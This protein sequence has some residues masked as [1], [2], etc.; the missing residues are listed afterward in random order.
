MFGAGFGE[1]FAGGAGDKALAPEFD[2]VAADEFFVA[3][4]IGDGDVAAVG[5]GVAALDGFPGG[6][7]ALAVFAFSRRDASRWRWDRKG[8]PRLAWRSGA[9]LRDTIGP[10]R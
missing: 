6:V 5:D 1:N 9:R 8:F 10:S 4:A 7:L 2:A 3:D